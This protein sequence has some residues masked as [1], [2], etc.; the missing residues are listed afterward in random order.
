MNPVG[1][2]EHQLA[3]TRRQNDLRLA[4]VGEV[5]CL[6]RKHRR[7][8]RSVEVSVEI[9]PATSLARIDYFWSP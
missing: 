2:G 7:R 8:T 5:L 6:G 1:I 3:G 4:R 9:F